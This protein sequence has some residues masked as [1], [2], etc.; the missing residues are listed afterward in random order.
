M[1]TEPKIPAIPRG[2]GAGL[3]AKGV[4][5]VLPASE[6]RHLRDSIH[7]V[8]ARYEQAHGNFQTR[9]EESWADRSP[10]DLSEAPL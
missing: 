5:E 3:R 4:G 6:A 7:R 9:V 1:S 2:R 8:F 10:G